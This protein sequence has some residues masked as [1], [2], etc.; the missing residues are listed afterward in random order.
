MKIIKSNLFFHPSYDQKTRDDIAP[1]VAEQ[2][3]RLLA[4]L[5][6]KPPPEK[7]WNRSGVF[8]IGQFQNGE[9]VWILAC[10]DFDADEPEPLMTLFIG[11][12]REVL[13]QFKKLCRA[14]NSAKIERPDGRN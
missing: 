4:G 9:Q 3:P 8:E 2:V 6:G 5:G 10:V 1:F 14:N 11:P 13:R 12:R 7:I